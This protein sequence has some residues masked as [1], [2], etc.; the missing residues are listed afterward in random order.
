[1]RRTE[2]KKSMEERY[3][4]LIEDPK[5]VKKVFSLVWIVAYSMLI[6]GFI[7][8]LWVLLQGQQTP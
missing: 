7:I 8:I 5:K 4:E 1:M 3:E 2:M 6:I